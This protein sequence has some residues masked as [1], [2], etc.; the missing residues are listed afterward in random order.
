M[1]ALMNMLLA[2]GVIAFGC[3]YAADEPTPPAKTEQKS[4]SKASHPPH[5]HA[6]E[7]G[8]IPQP[9]RRPKAAHKKK[10]NENRHE[11]YKEKH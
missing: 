8:T 5:S 9:E 4:E 10:L 1:K 7:K 2:V 11:H 6:A 3:A